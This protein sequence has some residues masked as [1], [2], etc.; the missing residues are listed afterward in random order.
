MDVV[1]GHGFAVGDDLEDG[2]FAGGVELDVGRAGD[3]FDDLA[4]FAGEGFEGG[5]V[6]AENFY[7]EVG[8]AAGEEFVEA[9]FDGLG[10]ELRLAGE[11]G[12]E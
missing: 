11:V 10:E 12:G 4:N 1:A 7:G 5:V 6:V 8:A 3:F 9:E 2:G